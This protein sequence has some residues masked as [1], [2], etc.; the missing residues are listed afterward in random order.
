MEIEVTQEKL[1]KALNLVSRI[2]VGAKATLPILANVL[3]RVNNGKMSLITTNLDMAIIDFVPVIDAKDGSITVPARLLTEFVQNLPSKEKISLKVDNNKIKI[4]AG[5]YSSIING[6]AS[7]DFPELP[8]MD[9]KKSV[10]YKM[11]TDEFK[12]GLEQIVIAASGDTTRPALTGIYFNTYEN[13][14]YIAATDGYRLA[15]RKFIDSVESEVKAIV[16]KAS[17]QEVLRS[18]PEQEEEVEFLFDDSQVRFRMGETEIISKLIDGPFPD[19]RRLIPNDNNIKLVLD[20]DEFV[21][22]VKMAGLFARESNRVICCE[23]DSEKKVLTVSSIS[24]EI[25]ENKSEISTEVKINGNVKVDSRYLL[26]ALNV[27][28]EEQV[29]FEFGD[30]GVPPIL[31]MNA[32]SKNYRHIVMPLDM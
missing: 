32:K 1:S 13:D 8:E 17:L 29:K 31:I 9:D 22:I 23:T 4:S 3:I 6:A 28:E 30:N 27:C 21:R 14:L 15:E 19:Y 7:E 25:G 10:I 2:A 20:R 12:S 16:P 11:P 24:N 5:K 18:I 26:E